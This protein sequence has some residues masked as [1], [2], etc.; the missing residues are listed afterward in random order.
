MVL[1]HKTSSPF[2][3]DYFGALVKDWRWIIYP[4]AMVEDISA[5]IDDLDGGGTEPEWIAE[6]LRDRN[7]LEIDPGTIRDILE[8]TGP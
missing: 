6:R 5:L 2:E 8:L 4:W 3:P 1:H 7:G